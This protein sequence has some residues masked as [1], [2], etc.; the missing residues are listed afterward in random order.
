MKFCY[1]CARFFALISPTA[2][3][4]SITQSKQNRSW[5]KGSYNSNNQSVSFIFPLS[6]LENSIK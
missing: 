1:F 4:T 3:T 5:V 6:N 2:H